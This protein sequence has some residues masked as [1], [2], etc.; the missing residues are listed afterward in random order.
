MTT[1][2]LA[3]TPEIR[4]PP[5]LLFVRGEWCDAADGGRFEVLNPATEE[6][7]AE[8]AAATPEDVDRAVQA[9]RAQ[10]DGGEWSRLSGAERGR[11][12][13]RAADLIER[14]LETLAALEALEVGKPIHEPRTSDIPNAAETFRHFAGWADKI[15]GRQIPV[16]DWRGRARLSYTRR[17]PIGVVGAITPWN[18]PTMIASW[19]LAPALAAGC[20][21]VLKPAP[22]A[23]LAALHLASLLA[24]SGLPPGVLNVVPGWGK[25]AGE[26]L[27][28]HPGVDK[29]SFTGS[30]EVGRRIAMLAGENLKAVGLELGGKSPQIVFA[31]A[32]IEAA[33]PIA[34]RGIFANQGEICAAATRV[35]VDS[36][37]KD[38]VAAGLVEAA[39][40]IQVGDPFEL[41]TTMGPLINEGQLERV[42]GYVR[43]GLEDG[44]ELLV[45]GQRLDRRGY[46]VEPTVFLGTNDQRIAQEEIFGPVGTVITFDDPDEA[47]RRANDTPYGLSAVVW[48][49]DLSRAHDTAARLRSGAVWVN[50]TGPPDPRLPWGGVKTSGV[51]RELGM[52]GIEA[53]TQ[54]KVVSIVL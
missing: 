39:R 43:A 28:R 54:E 34:A 29:V 21:V 31:D 25:V 16:P 4:L 33:L 22:D 15:H 12:L 3:P 50:A 11:I 7:I 32:D 27:V 51:G 17:E 1:S 10:V 2:G 40:N 48:T 46:F 38:D 41:G 6:R 19:K 13:T 18:A 8:V 36:R 5:P 49:R 44:A 26:A 35:I 45:G 47:I 42:M 53:N 20:A 30:P 14:D 24:E 23:P 9:A 37:I 52:A